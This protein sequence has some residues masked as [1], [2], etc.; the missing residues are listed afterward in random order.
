[1][2]KIVQFEIHGVQE[3]NI[4]EIGPTNRAFGRVQNF[5]LN[6]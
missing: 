5:N 4:P 1:M 2:N 6:F 3:S